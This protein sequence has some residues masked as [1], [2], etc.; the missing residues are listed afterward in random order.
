MA[1]AFA[2]AAENQR[3]QRRQQ[4]TRL[5]TPSTEHVYIMCQSVN[6]L[7]MSKILQHCYS[8]TFINCAHTASVLFSQS[9]LV[10]ESVSRTLAILSDTSFAQ[11]ICSPHKQH[12]T[13]TS[14]LLFH[15]IWHDNF[16]Q[17]RPWL[18]TCMYL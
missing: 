18:C 5:A 16:S 11:L 12:T 6:N 13:V 8:R 1:P 14:S 3:T 7:S 15:S 17:S 4:A 2:T 9:A 10:S